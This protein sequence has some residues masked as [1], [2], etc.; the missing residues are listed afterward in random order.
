MSQP[1]TQHR[2]RLPAHAYPGRVGRRRSL[3]SRS[4]RESAQAFDARSGYAHAATPFRILG[5]SRDLATHDRPRGE[6]PL[7]RQV[8]DGL[9]GCREVALCQ[10]WQEA[11]LCRLA[12]SA[13]L[14][15]VQG[16]FEG[17][18]PVDR[19]HGLG[20]SRFCLR[21][22]APKTPLQRVLARTLRGESLACSAARCNS[23]QALSPHLH[24]RC[25]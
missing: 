1:S 12:G 9:I 20:L 22:A 14:M 18:Q 25:T 7:C 16:W 17:K 5:S 11:V 3:R 21:Q 19:R 23:V 15:P 6:T 4:R 13:S 8:N 2:T 24:L 10:R